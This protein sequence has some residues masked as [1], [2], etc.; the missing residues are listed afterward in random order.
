MSGL[1]QNKVVLGKIENEAKRHEI[2]FEKVITQHFGSNWIPNILIPN[3]AWCV[4][5]STHKMSD[6]SFHE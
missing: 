2:Q 5:L 3:S 1:G 4:L 6:R